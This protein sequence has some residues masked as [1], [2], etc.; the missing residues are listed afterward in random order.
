M[1]SMPSARTAWAPI[2]LGSC[3]SSILPRQK[4]LS[5]RKS[6]QA[7]GAGY[8]ACSACLAADFIL[9]LL[10]CPASLFAA[11]RI[12]WNW[13]TRYFEVVVGQPVQVQVL[14][15][16]PNLREHVLTLSRYRVAALES[17]QSGWVRDTA[18]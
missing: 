9:R 8:S 16:A 15:C 14:L 11:L 18:R 5:L 3:C 7:R 13:Q 10:C 1:A 2:R 4:R 17:G 6:N 12:W